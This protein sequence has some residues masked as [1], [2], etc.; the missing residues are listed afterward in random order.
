MHMS[1]KCTDLKTN[2]RQI[3]SQYI[4]APLENAISY[5]YVYTHTHTHTHTHTWILISSC[6]ITSCLLV[7]L[8][9]DPNFD[10]I[11]VYS[12]QKVYY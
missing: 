12:A 1:P 2:E 8:N 5:K 11:M 6:F 3:L 4:H 9:F 7:P 10:E